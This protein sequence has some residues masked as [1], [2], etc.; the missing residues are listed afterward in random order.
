MESVAL[1]GDGAQ[2]LALGR[3]VMARHAALVGRIVREGGAASG[4]ACAP[5][6]PV[7]R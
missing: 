5:P 7:L 6:P 1:A 4:Q 3:E 2:A